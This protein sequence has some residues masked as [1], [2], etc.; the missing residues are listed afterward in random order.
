MCYGRISGLLLYVFLLN[1]ISPEGGP[2]PQGVAM[3]YLEIEQIISFHGHIHDQH[4]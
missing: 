1:R 2:T 4:H 3:E